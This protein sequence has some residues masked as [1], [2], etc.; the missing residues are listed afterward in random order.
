MTAIATPRKT[1]G[2]SAPEA[3]AKAAPKTGTLHIVD[4]HRAAPVTWDRNDPADVAEVE[5]LVANKMGEGYALFPATEG[6]IGAG[7]VSTFDAQVD[8]AFLVSPLQGG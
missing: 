7:P 2:T 6:G 8:E 4:G 5:G 1:T 3:P